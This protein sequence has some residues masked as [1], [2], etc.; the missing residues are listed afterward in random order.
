MDRD[1]IEQHYEQNKLLLERA[2]YCTSIGL[3]PSLKNWR[4]EKLFERSNTNDR[5]AEND[6]FPVNYW[7]S[8]TIQ[9]VFEKN[10]QKKSEA[11][12]QN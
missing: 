10:V 2:S 1:P 7:K 8:D 6:T 3:L 9:G 12:Y 11:V 4:I 5:T